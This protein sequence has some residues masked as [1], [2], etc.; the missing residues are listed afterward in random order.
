MGYF[1]INNDC[2]SILKLNT[3]SKGLLKN[4]SV[5]ELFFEVCS[6]S[7]TPNI[8]RSIKKIEN[9]LQSDTFIYLP[10]ITAE[11]NKK[12]QEIYEVK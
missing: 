1:F 3:N 4:Y 7:K 10:V 6:L 5:G 9:L 11:L 2:D 12:I 8:S